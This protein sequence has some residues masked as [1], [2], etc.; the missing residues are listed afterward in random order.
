MLFTFFKCWYRMGWRPGEKILVFYPR[1]TY[2][3]D[4]LARFNKIGW[5]SGFRIQLFDQID[6]SSIRELVLMN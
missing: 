3:I 1:N 2:N 6:E 5:L 4:D